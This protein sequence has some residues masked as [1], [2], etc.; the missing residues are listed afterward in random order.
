MNYVKATEVDTLL[1]TNSHKVIEA[2]LIDYIMSLRQDSISYST[3]KYLVAPI[4][5]FYQ[6]NDILLNKKKVFRYL[7]EFKRVVKDKAYT[8]EQIR[9]S[10]Q[11]TTLTHTYNYSA[12]TATSPLLVHRLSLLLFQPLALYSIVAASLAR[13]SGVLPK[14]RRC[15]IFAAKITSL[16][17]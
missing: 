10:L 15:L 7:G 16:P 3:I 2:Q 14:R 5:T 13:P 4:F 9:Q 12:L 17:R 11:S 6:L 8:I 1:E